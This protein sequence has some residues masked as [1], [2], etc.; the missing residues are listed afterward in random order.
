MPVDSLSSLVEA[1]ISQLPDDP[2][3]V[4][5]SV[6]SENEPAS[7]TNGQ[8]HPPTGSIY[9]PSIVYVLELCTVLALR[10][11]ETISSLGGDVAEALQNVM[12]NAS[13]Y[14]H[15]MISRTMYYVLHLLHASYEHSFLRVPVVLHTIS[16]FKKDLLDKS[17]PLVLQGLRQCIKDP[18]PLRNEIMTS[19]DFWVILRNL[20]ANALA[21]PTVFEILEGVAVGSPPTIMADNYES[22]V[23]LLNEFASAG[24]VGATVEQKQDKRVR[25]GQPPVKQEK[26]PQVEAAVKRGVKAITMIYS[27][28]DRIPSLMKQSHLESQEAWAAYW[29]PIF[30]ALTT[31][32][33]NPCR[34]IRHQAFSSLQRTLVSQS[35]T[36]GDHEEWTAIFGEVLFPL[37]VRLLKPEVYS[38]D[39][40]GM[41]ETRVQAATLLCKIFLHHLAKLSQW[42]GMLDLWLKILDI[43]D[44]LMN[45]GQGDSLVS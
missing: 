37:I 1:L 36:S 4:V 41:S 11:S 26:K 25:R 23:K 34:E 19:P 27:L 20:T 13:S 8:K 2:S 6:K 43:M 24:R 15:I 40:V 10:D 35:L 33:T 14:H 32:C 16:S 5:I 42:E 44:R 3:S 29:S 39:P 17:A 9:D 22:A 38:S 30:G 28:T 31:Q 45:S 18:G 12:R 7:P 21:A